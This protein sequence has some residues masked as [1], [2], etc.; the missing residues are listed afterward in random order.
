MPQQVPP[1]PSFDERS[2][3]AIESRLLP[4]DKNV[5]FGGTRVIR[6]G[7]YVPVIQQNLTQKLT[8]INQDKK[9]DRE[10]MLRRLL[11]SVGQNTKP[12]LQIKDMVH[13]TKTKIL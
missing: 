11:Q 5:V 4:A 6:R 10:A 9:D 13:P 8:P 12:G 3:W 7:R 1:F 2:A